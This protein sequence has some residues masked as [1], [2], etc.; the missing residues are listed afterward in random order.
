M[1]HDCPDCGQAC[2]CD[3]DDVFMDDYP[4][5]IHECAEEPPDS[6]DDYEE[7]EVHS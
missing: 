7:M 4:E 5:C 6:F 1:A 2:Y 3:G